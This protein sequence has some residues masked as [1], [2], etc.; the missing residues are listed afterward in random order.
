MPYLSLLS[1]NTLSELFKLTG[2]PEMS[3]LEEMQPLFIVNSYLPNLQKINTC[4][5]PAAYLVRYSQFS[6][7]SFIQNLIFHSTSLDSYW[8]PNNGRMSTRH[9]P[10]HPF[11]GSCRMKPE[12]NWR[13]TILATLPRYNSIHPLIPLEIFFPHRRESFE[14]LAKP[15][16]APLY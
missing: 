4:H 3:V 11:Y 2:K 13:R 6:F 7:L 10:M 5:N 14:Y 8:Q 16:S 12:R 15:P 1:F 9:G